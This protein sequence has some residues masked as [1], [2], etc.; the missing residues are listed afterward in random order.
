MYTCFE[1]QEPRENTVERNLYLSGY[2]DSFDEFSRFGVQFFPILSHLFYSRLL[3]LFVK[4]CL[5][6]GLILGK[7]GF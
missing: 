1:I 4:V 5:I 2:Y 3:Y 6:M 7:L